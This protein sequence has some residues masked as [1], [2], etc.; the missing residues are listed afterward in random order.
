MGA[1]IATNA[2]AVWQDGYLAPSCKATGAVRSTFFQP[3]GYSLWQVD[4]ELSAGA[5][6]RWDE[7]GHGDEAVHVLEGELEV[8]GLRCGPEG[9]AIVEAGAGACVRAISDARI[10]HFGPSAA[11]PPGNGL[12]GPPTDSGRGAHV[13]SVEEA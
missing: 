8:D 13:V 5:E 4:A 6:L 2:D 1:G 12:F 10:V 3:D 11:A 9:T 7:D